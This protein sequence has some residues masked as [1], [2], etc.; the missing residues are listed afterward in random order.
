MA[1]KQKS[2]LCAVLT[3]L[4][5][6]MVFIGC[7]EDELTRHKEAA[8]ASLTA[9]VGTLNSQDFSNEDWA[10]IKEIVNTGK[11]NINR[12]AS[13]QGVDSVLAQAKYEIGWIKNAHS[14]FVMTLSAERTTFHQGGD[15]RAIWRLEN[16]SEKD[17]EIAWYY[18]RRV[19]PLLSGKDLIEGTWTRSTNPWIILLKADSE[20]ESGWPFFTNSFEPGIHV[21]RARTA[22]Y[23]NFGQENQQLVRMRSNPIFITLTERNPETDD[24]VLTF[25]AEETTFMH[26]ENIRVTVELKN[27]SGEDH[28][29]RHRALFHYSFS[30]WRGWG[31]T[32]LPSH[33]LSERFFEADSV[34]TES[35]LIRVRDILM[36]GTHELR[37]MAQFHI[38]NISLCGGQWQLQYVDVVSNTIV[39][40]VKP[41]C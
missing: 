28:T 1:T 6:A 29:I 31:T 21:L 14:D 3:A 36:P 4:L 20:I 5:L 10:E 16:I 7:G 24:F 9:Y 23:L 30:G 17:H 13:K 33:P 8:I 38:V 12:A 37:L 22:F 41:N 32:G 26:G 39:I 27:N 11:R 34:I 19:R 18:Y 25:T 2:A 15:L 35:R 40:T